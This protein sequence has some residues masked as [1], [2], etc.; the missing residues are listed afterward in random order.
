[1]KATHITPST[2]PEDMYLRREWLERF[3]SE[4]GNLPVTFN[5]A[6]KYFRA[7]LLNGTRR[8]PGGG[9]MPTW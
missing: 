9:S 1:M 7:S 4:S 2:Q 8:L 3:F 5:Y 6:G